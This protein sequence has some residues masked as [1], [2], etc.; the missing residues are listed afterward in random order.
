MGIH[1]LKA[2]RQLPTIN[3]LGFADDR[4]QAALVNTDL[5]ASVS[6]RCTLAL[7]FPQVPWEAWAA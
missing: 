6:L 4:W 7:H 2:G 3:P 1:K 5:C